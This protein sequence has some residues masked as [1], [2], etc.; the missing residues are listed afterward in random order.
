MTVEHIFPQSFFE[1]N[2]LK[3]NEYNL[4]ILCEECNREKGAKLIPPEDFKK[5]YKFIDKQH[6]TEYFNFYVKCLWRFS[7]KFGRKGKE[8]MK[9]NKGLEQE[10]AELNNQIKKHE[11]DN[12]KLK[13]EIKNLKNRVK[14]AH[15]NVT[16]LQKRCDKL[17]DKN[18]QLAIKI[19]ELEAENKRLIEENT[20]RKDGFRAIF[21]SIVNW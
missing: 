6:I 8:A 10:I 18:E 14:G 1:D 5:F 4:T 11:A 19:E 2:T 7:D 20:R 21:R 17:E 3:D 16:G 12:T 13:S 9:S 15:G